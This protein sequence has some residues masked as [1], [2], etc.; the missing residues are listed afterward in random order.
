MEETKIG[1]SLGLINC[2][3][4]TY[5]LFIKKKKNSLNI[6]YYIKIHNS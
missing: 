2:G 1:N 3:V 4:A 5:F 6:S